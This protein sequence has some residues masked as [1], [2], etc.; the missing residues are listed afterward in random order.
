MATIDER[1]FE[2][3]HDTGFKHGPG[4]TENIVSRINRAPHSE[5]ISNTSVERIRCTE[6]RRLLGA[7]TPTSTLKDLLQHHD[8]LLKAARTV[9][10]SI[11]DVVIQQRWKW[12]WIHNISLT[13]YVGGAKDGGPQKLWEELEAEKCGVHIPAEIRWLGGAKVR[14]RFQK[15]REG[16]SSAAVAVQGETTFNRLWRYGVRLFGARYEVDAYRRCDRM[17]SAAG[18]VVGATLPH[19]VRP[20]HPSAPSARRIMKRQPPVPG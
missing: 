5:G 3:P 19:T 6:T 2:L 20:Q 17:P 1:V 16:I 13:R 4:G 11:S 7:T 14:A 8:M 18:I 15:R 12:I 9:D 10:A